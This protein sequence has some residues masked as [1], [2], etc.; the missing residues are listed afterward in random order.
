[1]C[2]IKEQSLATVRAGSAGSVIYLT[3]LKQQRIT[4]ADIYRTTKLVI[5]LLFNNELYALKPCL[6]PFIYSIFKAED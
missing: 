1:V 4:K 3:P 5:P 2:C 6:A